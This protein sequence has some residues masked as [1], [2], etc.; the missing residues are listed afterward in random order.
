MRIDTPVPGQSLTSAPG[1]F[2]YERPPEINDPE[3]AIQMHLSRLSKKVPDVLDALEMGVDIKT[4]TEGI[5][6]SAVATG[7][8]SIDTS[9]I[10]APVVH[11]FIR[12]TAEKAGIDFDEGLVDAKHEEKRKRAVAQA[13]TLKKLTKEKGEISPVVPK[14]IMEEPKGLLKRR[15]K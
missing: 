11:E 4:L 7:V 8:H 15:S 3:E 2:P 13:K 9:L 10:I 12:T 6:R 1:G 5:L 14:E